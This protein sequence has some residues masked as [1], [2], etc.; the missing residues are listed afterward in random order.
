[1][2]P[3]V[4]A[5]SAHYSFHPLQAHGCKSNVVGWLQADRRRKKQLALERKRLLKFPCEISTIAW[6]Q[7]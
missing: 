5:A 3:D 6:L 1:M 7:I 2:G 4:L